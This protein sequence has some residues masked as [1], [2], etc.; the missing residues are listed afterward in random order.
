MKIRD[1]QTEA[2]QLDEISRRDFLKGIGAVAGST[3]LGNANSAPFSHGEYKD[4]MTGTSEGRFSKVRS[5]DGKAILEISW[6]ENK[7]PMTVIEIPGATINFG[8][9]GSSGRIKIGDSPVQ[10]FGLSQGK[11]GN[12]S[13]G[14][15]LD[16][17][18]ARKLLTHSGP[19]KVEVEL[20]RT[21]AVIFNFTLEQDAVTSQIKA[22]SKNKSPDST[23]KSS[24]QIRQDQLNRLKGN[25]TNADYA[26]RVV[27]RIKPNI[28]FTGEVDGNPVASVEVKTSNDGTVLSRRLTSS[29]GNKEWDDAVLR[30]IDRTQTLPRNTDGTVPSTLQINFR[31]K[32]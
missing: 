27:A 9:Y 5:N 18:I 25:A 23:S 4:Q 32:D 16:K 22:P 21:G 14:A 11:S 19:V 15:N 28:N 3:A 10:N 2:Q 26:N 1:L 12:Y 29:S 20:F 17:G 13:W 30:A 7:M 31:P 24:D 8:V 6:P